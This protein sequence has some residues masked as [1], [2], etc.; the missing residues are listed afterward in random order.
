MHSFIFE[1]VEAKKF[2][3]GDFANLEGYI[4]WFNTWLAWL[5]QLRTMS[6]EERMTFA[7]PQ[8]VP[9]M[10]GSLWPEDEYVPVVEAYTLFDLDLA[11][12]QHKVW[13]ST[14]KRQPG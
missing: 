4:A 1:G 9:T 3:S 13:N 7:L 11:K 14:E 10:G 6:H 8:L 2:Q 12:V 5:E